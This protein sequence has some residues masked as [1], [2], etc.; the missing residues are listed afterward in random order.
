MLKRK[1]IESRLQ[2]LV[3]RF[4]SSV[5]SAP[6]P[7]FFVGVLVGLAVALFSKVLIPLFLVAT[8]VILL[9]WFLADRE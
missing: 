7:A 6:I 5:E 4:R 9:L 1:E 8:I 2:E 3:E